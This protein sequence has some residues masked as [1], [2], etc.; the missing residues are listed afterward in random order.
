MKDKVNNKSFFKIYIDSTRIAEVQPDLLWQNVL[1]VQNDIKDKNIEEKDKKITFISKNLFY[2]CK[3]IWRIEQIS[4]K[5]AKLSVSQVY[6]GLFL[7][8]FK[9]FLKRNFQKK[10]DSEVQNL[11]LKS[12]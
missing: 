5:K 12:M 10:I 6:S 9:L 2:K 1:S 7:F 4:P 8:P 3:N 11:I